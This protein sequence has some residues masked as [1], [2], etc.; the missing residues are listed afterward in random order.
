M[1][2]SQLSISQA[3]LRRRESQIRKGLAPL[4]FVGK[5]TLTGN[6]GPAFVL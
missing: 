6:N 4:H 3:L 1:L 2:A 5:V